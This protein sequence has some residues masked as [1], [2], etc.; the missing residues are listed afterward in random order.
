MSNTLT[1]TIKLKNGQE[2][3]PGKISLFPEHSHSSEIVRLMDLPPIEIDHLPA[4]VSM[5][6]FADCPVWLR[7]IRDDEK[8]ITEEPLGAFYSPDSTR[9]AI[10]APGA[11][12]VVLHIYDQPQG[13]KPTKYKLTKIQSS[14]WSVTIKGD[15]KGKYYVYSVAGPDPA[16][17]PKKEV[18][19]PYTTC[20]TTHDCQR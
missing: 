19:D 16:Y 11:K 10:F 14:L 17:E 20:A 18:L 15:L 7:Y 9:F 4:T 12:T 3:K 2:I 8:F 6:N 5:S 1:A 13:G